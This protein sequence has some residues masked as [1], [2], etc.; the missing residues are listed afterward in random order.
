MTSGFLFTFSTVTTLTVG[1]MFIMWL[2]EQ[3]TEHGVGNG[4]SLL[5]FFSIIEG[6]PAAVVRTWEAMMVGEIGIVALAA[7]LVVVV[8]VTA[9][10]VSMTMGARQIP[11]QIPERW[12][13]GGGSRR[14]RSR[15]CRSGECGRR[16]ADHLRAV[17]HHRSRNPGRVL[18]RELRARARRHVPARKLAYYI[19]Y[20][21]SRSSSPISIR[22]S[23]STPWISPRT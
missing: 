11:V 20:G 16:D 19:A 4:M 8:G 9:G 21:S 2:G 17:V 23:S 5:I 22:P 1:G 12:W 18:E 15:T 7:L 10:V 13:G 14:A 3:I 6:F